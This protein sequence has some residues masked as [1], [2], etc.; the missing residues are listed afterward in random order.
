MRKGAEETA[1]ASVAL[2][3]RVGVREGEEETVV[4]SVPMILNLVSGVIS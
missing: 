2:V 3:S 4:H 1:A